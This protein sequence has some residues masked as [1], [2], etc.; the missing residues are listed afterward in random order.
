VRPIVTAVL[1]AVVAT[2]LM[3]PVLG[4]PHE[5]VY[6]E[7]SDPLGEVW[8]LEQFRTGEIGLV[9]NRIADTAN[10]PDGV[11]LRRALDVTQALY[12]L[13]A[14]ALVKLMPAV[15]AYNLLVWLALWTSAVAAAWA[16]VRLGVRWEGALAGGIALMVAPVHMIEAQLHVGLAFTAPLPVVLAI[17]VGVRRRPSS[18]GGALLGAAAAAC[19]YVTAYLSLQV[20]AVLVGLS[21]AAVVIGVARRQIHCG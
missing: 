7:P 18:R 16:L 19:A 20:L 13:P 12:D 15:P 4:A 21:A 1:A 10:V 3:W 6:G 14:V 9:G 11:E 2:L 5:R 8:R 17:G